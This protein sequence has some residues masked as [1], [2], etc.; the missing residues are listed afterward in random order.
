MPAVQLFVIVAGAAAA[1]LGWRWQTARERERREAARRLAESLGYRLDV[2]TKPP[3]EL[4]FDLFRL[5]HGRK[6]TYQTWRD[7]SPD[8]AFQYEY[9]TGSGKN[10][11]THRRTAALI[12]VSFLAPHLTIG[13]EGFW[14]SVGRTVGIRDIEIES[15]AF[16]DRYRVRCED[17]RFAITLLD[18]ELIA[19][20]LTPASGSGAV[21]FELVGPWMLC[22][23]DRIE[24]EVLIPF[25]QWAQQARAQLPEVLTSLYP[26]A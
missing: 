6:V 23:G 16:N 5:G 15:E 18:H 9:T 17:E 14:S 3:P 7:G 19:W 1:V 24:F 20:M 4:G 2:T 25:L 12:R 22:W 10:R 13:P 21:S 8:S 26:P 11:R